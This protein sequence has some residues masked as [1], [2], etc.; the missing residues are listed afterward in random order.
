MQQQQVYIGFLLQHWDAQWIEVCVLFVYIYIIYCKIKMCFIKKNVNVMWVSRLPMKIKGRGEMHPY[1]KRKRW[2]AIT[3]STNVRRVKAIN[4][5]P[6]HRLQMLVPPHFSC[7]PSCG[8]AV[9]C[10]FPSL[11][12]ESSPNIYFLLSRPGRAGAKGSLS[13]QWSQG[14]RNWCPH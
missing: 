8:P 10:T 11:S 6:C 1:M 2:R 3:R 7:C 4:T 13:V 5:P 14:S 9:G 12:K